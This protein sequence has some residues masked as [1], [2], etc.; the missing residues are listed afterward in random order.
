MNI[1]PVSN[2]VYLENNVSENVKGKKE[3]KENKIQDKLELS[4]EA[5]N[6]R[7]KQVPGKDLNKIKDRINSK[8]YGSDEIINKIADKILKDILPKE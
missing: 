3:I 4:E 2:K 6:I 8:Y 7:K 1:K 5:K